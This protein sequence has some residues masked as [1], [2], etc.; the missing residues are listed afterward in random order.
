MRYVAKIHVLDVLEDIVLSGYIYD[1]DPMSDPD[2]QP[3]EFTWQIP[4]VGAND[5]LLW[6][7]DALRRGALGMSAAPGG[8]S[9][10]AVPMG[11]PHTISETGDRGI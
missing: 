8:S 2:H 7:L 6:L 11:G 9:S 10:G 5:G 1:S 4:G 3:Y